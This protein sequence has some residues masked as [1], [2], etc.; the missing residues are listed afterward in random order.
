MIG[1]F[2]IYKSTIVQLAAYLGGVGI[3]VTG[4]VCLLSFDSYVTDI[5]K[6]IQKSERKSLENKNIKK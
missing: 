6:H 5:D 3:V 1:R 2:L 4:I